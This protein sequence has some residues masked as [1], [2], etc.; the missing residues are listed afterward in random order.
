[1]KLGTHID[2]IELNKFHTACHRLRPQ[3]VGYLVLLRIF[4]FLYIFFFISKPSQGFLGALTCSKTLENLHTHW[5]PRP[6]GRRRGWDPGVA[7]GSTAPP[8]AQSEN[9]M[10]SSHILARIHMKL[11]THIDLIEP[12]NFHAACH[13]L[14]PTGSR[15]LGLFK[16]RMLWNLIYSSEDYHPIATKLGEHDLKTLGTQ[17]CQDIFDISNGLPV[18]RR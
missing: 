11:G 12:N 6:S 16:K 9:L 17:N 10:Y 15:L 5:N 7:Q 1:M 4:Y 8:G 13:R 3:E 14:R 18:A 2:L